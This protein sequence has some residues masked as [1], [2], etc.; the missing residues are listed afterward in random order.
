VEFLEAEIMTVAR[1]DKGTAVL[2]RP[3][4]AD[5]AVPIFIGQLEAHS[6]LIGLGKVPMPRP[7]THDL[8]LTI[9]EHAKFNMERVDI[10]NL[11]EGTFFARICVKH[12]VKRHEL[13][14]RPSD[15]LALVARTGTPL[16]ISKAIV[17]EA[18]I[19][20]NMISEQTV[21]EE[22]NETSTGE[23]ETT[24]DITED[25]VYRRISLQHQLDQAIATEDYEEAARLRDSLKTL[26][27][28]VV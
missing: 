17:D 27:G 25:P 13:D 16:F 10:W 1:T 19:P 4:S 26:D 24:I 15:A 22:T 20:V 8:L 9:M 7:L 14:A 3:V 12:G 5:R 2:V 23:S 6:I 21:G 28:P 18:G 11:K